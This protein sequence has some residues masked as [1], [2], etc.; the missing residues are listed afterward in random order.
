M[1]KASYKT[2]SRDDELALI[3]RYQAGRKDGATAAEKRSGAAAGAVLLKAHAAFIY[4]WSTGYRFTRGQDREEFLQEGKIGFLRAVE[5]Y[6]PTGG[7]KLITYATKAIWSSVLRYWQDRGETVHIPTYMHNLAA[8]GEI[9]DGVE[10]PRQKLSFDSPSNPRDWDSATL[11]EVLSVDTEDAET[12]LAREQEL[13]F[14]VSMIDRLRVPRTRDIM[15]R[16]YTGEGSTL[17]AVGEAIGLSRERVRQ[18][19]AKALDEIKAMLTKSETIRTPVK[20]CMAIEAQAVATIESAPEI[21]HDV[22]N[23]VVVEMTEATPLTEAGKRAGW[24]EGSATVPWAATA[25][26][27]GSMRAAHL[28]ALCVDIYRLSGNVPTLP[29]RIGQARLG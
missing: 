23:V 24:G 8:H 17:S 1:T 14:I 13:E 19:E 18:I 15:R 9:P 27:F 2:L 5:H 29:R 20:M 6:D 12:S 26:D 16:L 28:A 11:G 22:P 10:L 3:R 21:E 4:K 7:A 25:R